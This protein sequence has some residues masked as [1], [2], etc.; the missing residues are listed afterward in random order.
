VTGK[1][2]PSNKQL[3]VLMAAVLVPIIATAKLLGFWLPMPF[4]WGVSF[5]VWSFAI[6]WIPPRPR[7]KPWVWLIIVSLLSVLV[8]FL[9][10]LGLN[11]F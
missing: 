1:E 9:V 7:M 11:P 2:T 3:P 6:F 10:A 4:A 5:F 8:L